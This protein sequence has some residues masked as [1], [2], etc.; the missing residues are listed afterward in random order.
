MKP[1]NLKKNSPFTIRKAELAAIANAGGPRSLVDQLFIVI[2]NAIKNQHIS[3]GMRMPS[4]RQLAD[5]CE[6]SPDTAARAYDKLV[7]N[8]FLESK[9]GSGFFI[10]THSAHKRALEKKFSTKNI[11]HADSRF[12]V[13]RLRM[14][15]LKPPLSSRSLS[16]IGYLAESWMDE[17]NI[18]SELR[19]VARGNQRT[20]AHIGDPQGY[21]PLRNQL[22]FKLHD[23]AI[24]CGADQ[25][26][27]TCGAADAINLIVQSYLQA[28]G[29]TV[30]VE[31]PC[32]PIII[33]R[34]MANG[35]EVHRVPRLAD[36]P[37]L[38]E[39][40]RLCE[41]Y[42]PRFFFCQS[43]IHNP[44]CSHIS[45]HIAFQLLRMAEEFDFIIVE[46]DSYGDLLPMSLSSS[47]SRLAPLDQFKRVI[48]IGSFSKT[49]ASGLRVGYLIANMEQIEWF[50]LHRSFSCMA[51]NSLAE[52]TVYRI[53]SEGNYR[54][55][56]EQL[57][58]RLNHLRPMAVQ[59]LKALDI[60]IEQEPDSG[61]YL[62]ANL[63]EDLNAFDVA[64]RM[65]EQ[66]H[67][68][69]P[70]NLFSLDEQYR[71]YMRFNIT[72]CLENGFLAA[73]GKLLGRC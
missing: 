72:T 41:E 49:L 50:I 11:F 13:L 17:V 53:L 36:G 23:L 40:R 47:A 59:E 18:S 48:Y 44:K 21:L 39:L 64:Q 31:D 22:Q 65:L 30:I 57:R 52:R 51:N 32:Q 16:G 73:L 19:A 62:W 5:D 34:L 14:M 69:A 71:S 35:L 55:H 2:S 70:G 26:I 15:L 8:G 63:G 28:P 42:R 61:F 46:D 24:Q 37:D 27:L 12:D 45:P 60:Q 33:P 1:S 68:T 66:N 7:A 56:C 58:T 6:I 9:R 43:M 38:D 4:V 3:Q 67:L 10:R 25:I 29:E 20:L 54:H